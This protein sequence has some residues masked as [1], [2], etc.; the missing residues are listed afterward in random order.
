MAGDVLDNIVSPWKRLETIV[1]SNTN[2]AIDGLIDAINDKYKINGSESAVSS[3]NASR[4]F[5]VNNE[6]I[7]SPLISWKSSDSIHTYSTTPDTTNTFHVSQIQP[8]L[9]LN[10]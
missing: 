1:A 4:S 5:S 6:S 10:H 7:N 9:H 3:S 2:V 8:V